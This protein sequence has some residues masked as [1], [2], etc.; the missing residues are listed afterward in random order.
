M[1]HCASGKSFC[2]A[3]AQMCAAVCRIFRSSSLSSEVISLIGSG[4]VV[5]SASSVDT[6][7]VATFGGVMR[8]RLNKFTF[9]ASPRHAAGWIAA[10]G[11]ALATAF[12]RRIA[13]HEG[14]PTRRA[15]RAA[16]CIF[17]AVTSPACEA[18]LATGERAP[19]RAAPGTQFI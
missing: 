4:S 7:E 12:A 9:P 5:V 11:G 15:R 2:V 17:P 19:T 8:E 3:I 18:R 10:S 16:N 14:G 1:V 6:A 13:L